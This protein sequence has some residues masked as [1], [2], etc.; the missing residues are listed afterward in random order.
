MMPKLS[1][2]VDLDNYNQ[3]GNGPVFRLVID[4]KDSVYFLIPAGLEYSSK[5]SGVFPVFNCSCG[6]M[7]CGGACIKVSHKHNK[8]VWEKVVDGQSSGE[9]SEGE[10]NIPLEFKDKTVIT[11]PIEFDKKEYNQVVKKLL[12]DMKKYKYEVD[13]YNYDV[14]Q[15]AKGNFFI[16]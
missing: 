15:F 8:I 9:D 7:G 12:K 5:K 3:M 14:A 13:G 1:Y 16:I 4:N 10:P 2:F 6:V 11:A